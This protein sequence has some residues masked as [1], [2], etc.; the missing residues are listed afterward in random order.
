MELQDNTFDLQH[1]IHE[2]KHFL[3]HQPPL[4]DFIHHNTLHA[5]Q[6]LSFFE[7]LNKAY[8]IFGYKVTLSINEY[9]DAYESGR[10]SD[11]VL[12]EVLAKYYDESSRQVWRQKM[13]QR[14]VTHDFDSRIGNVRENWKTQLG[15]DM[16]ALVHPILFRLLCS[17]LDQGISIWNFP[18]HKKGLLS[19]FK[20]LERNGFTSF[21]RRKRARKLLL[22]TECKLEDLLKI[23]VGSESLFEHYLFDQQF[24][25]Q[26]WSGMVSVI[27]SHREMMLDTKKIATYDMMVIECLLEIDALDYKMGVD[28]WKPIDQYLQYTPKRLFSD[29]RETEAFTISKLWH[30]AFEWSY[31]YPV[32]KGISDNLSVEKQKKETSFQALFC[33]DDRECSWRRYIEHL[34]PNCATFGTPGFFGVEFYF[35]PEGGKFYTKVCPAPVTPKYLIKEVPKSS[36]NSLLKRVGGK[37]TKDHSIHH[38]TDIHFSKHV[39]NSYFG[40]LFSQFVGFFSIFQLILIVFKPTRSAATASA[41]NHMEK[42]DLLTI[43]NHN[44]RQEKNLQVGFTVEEMTLRVKNVLYSIG[45]VKDFAPI[46]YVIGHGASST[47]NPYYAGYDCGACSGRAGSVNAR[48]FSHMANHPEVR[49]NLKAFGIEIPETTQFMG[50]LHDTT[51]DLVQFFDKDAMF[52]NNRSFH[53]KNKALM[54]EALLM[55]A[56]ERSR[57][58]DNVDS[59][60]SNIEIQEKL[61]LRSVSL[62]E[63]RPEYN[64][65]T[66]SLCIIGRRSMTKSLY[67]DRRAFLNSYDYQVDPQGQFLLGILNAAAPVCGGINLEYFFSRTDNLKLGAGSKLP[68]NVMGLFGVANG[69]EG[70]LRP[71]LPAQ[72]IEI[73][74]PLRLMMIVEH[75][76]EIVLNTI[77]VNPATYQWFENQWIHL[78]VVHPEEKR[79][80]QFTDGKFELMKINQP[81]THHIDLSS[82]VKQ[83]E[84]NKG[85][86]PVFL[87]EEN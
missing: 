39:L 28:Q 70:D 71:G 48:V 40:W 27:E 64:H 8:E 47:N 19:S 73:H 60:S 33:I 3:P 26:G 74:D 84:V 79:F 38:H 75:F 22:E 85:N 30:E 55:N 51:Q 77:K 66:N 83:F 17:F 5:F 37:L 4:K 23:L 78:V 42:K 1:T 29:V 59:Q 10:I 46:V 31:Y 21:F 7:G 44:N 63:P 69:I 57:R 65:A 36:R 56:K 67:L 35:Q 43:E 86:M 68:H 72:M 18:I 61:K 12:D 49:E 41:F 76:P 34:D 52:D 80:Y 13:M 62:F 87:I 20:E 15:I 81:S 2:I 24:E 11:Q 32:L 9:I 53:L 58:F 16:D 82:L 54:R 25:H 6:D 50:A 14:E 45:L